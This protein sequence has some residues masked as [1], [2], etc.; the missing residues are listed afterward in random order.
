MSY[1]NFPLKFFLC[2]INRA[3]NINRGIKKPKNRYEK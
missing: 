3:I 2:N 1:N